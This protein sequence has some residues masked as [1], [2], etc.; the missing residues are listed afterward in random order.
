MQACTG[1]EPHDP[2]VFTFVNSVLSAQDLNSLFRSL[3]YCRIGSIYFPGNMFQDKDAAE[4]N[5]THINHCFSTGIYKIE[6]VMT[7]ALT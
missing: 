4:R 7:S 6:I 2:Y 1:Y 5:F 3:S